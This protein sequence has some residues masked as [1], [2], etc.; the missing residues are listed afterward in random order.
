MFRGNPLRRRLVDTTHSFDIGRRMAGS[1]R[2]ESTLCSG[3]NCWTLANCGRLTFLIDGKAY[4]DAILATFPKAVHRIVIVGWD[5][6]D[7]APLRPGDPESALGPF[8][9]RCVETR[10]ALDIYVLIWRNSIFYGSNPFPLPTPFGSDWWD[11]PRIHFRLDDHHP[12]GACHHQ[13]IVCV[14]DALAFTGGMD[15]TLGRWDEPTHLP[16]HPLRVDAQG[17]PYGAVH[18]VQ[19]MIGGEAVRALATIAGERWR[20]LT[21]EHLPPVEAAD[22]PWPVAISPDLSDCRIAIARTLPAYGGQCEAREVDALIGDVVRTAKRF[23]YIEHQYFAL[24]AVVDILAEHL[25]R[26]NG[27][28]VV[29][30]V[31]QQSSGLL[32]QYVM[33]EN[34]DRLFAHL[35]AADRHGRLRTYFSAF[36]C[37]PLRE[38]KIHSKL[39]IVDGDILHIGSSNLNSRSTGLDTECDLAIEAT[40]PTARAAVHRLLTRLLAEHV[41]ADTVRFAEEFA[42]TKSLIRAIEAF[43]GGLRCL[44]PH[45][46]DRAAADKPLTA[47][48]SVLDPPQPIDLGYVWNKLTSSQ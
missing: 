46:I 3:R 26:R 34:R 27:P 21:G 20:Q 44:V 7:R 25:A 30:V 36:R 12:I 4:F 28:E 45:A 47:G 6:D 11:H 31:T 9:R 13:K 22:E 32:E 43:N 33:A 42:R 40:T 18:D 1:S 39:V 38:I 10:P 24:P 37:D 16:D 2:R 15:L 5:F 17:K 35:H 8:L 48:T 41:G 23:I 14:D 19:C 29:I